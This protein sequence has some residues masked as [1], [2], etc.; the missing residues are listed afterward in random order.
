MRTQS[1]A[2]V[3]IQESGVRRKAKARLR[4]NTTTPRQ[5]E[6]KLMLGCGV[7]RDEMG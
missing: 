3:R 1:K 7:G 4:Y 6:K 5:A 2:E